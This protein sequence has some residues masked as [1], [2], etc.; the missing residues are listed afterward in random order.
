MCFKIANC[1]ESTKD[2]ERL[3]IRVKQMIKACFSSLHHASFP[4]K[5]AKKFRG[6]FRDFR[7]FRRFFREFIDK[8]LT[9]MRKEVV[10]LTRVKLVTVL[11][12]LAV[13]KLDRL[14]LD[15]HMVVRIHRGQPYDSKTLTNQFALIAEAP[16][17][18]FRDNLRDYLFTVLTNYCYLSTLGLWPVWG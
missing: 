6:F 14:T 12:R 18:K 7:D 15:Q 8:K 16:E 2:G 17:T 3:N 13:V 5:Q 1:S 11:S 9:R 4:L 10:V